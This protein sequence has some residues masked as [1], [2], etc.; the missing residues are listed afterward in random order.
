MTR[1]EYKQLLDQSML[2]LA[3]DAR[4]QAFMGLI[5]DSKDSVSADLCNDEVLSDERKTMA[6]IGE[7]RTYQHLLDVYEQSR[8]KISQEP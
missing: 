1:D 4:F 7:M 5:R 2:Q 3:G 8:A 6:A